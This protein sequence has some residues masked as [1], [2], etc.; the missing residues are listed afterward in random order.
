VGLGVPARE[1]LAAVVRAAPLEV[2]VASEALVEDGAE[3]VEVAGEPREPA[4]ELLH[5]GVAGA[6]VATDDGAAVPLR[7]PRPEAGQAE[8]EQ[9]RAPA[10]VE[11]DV[12]GVDVAVE[13]ALVVEVVQGASELEAELGDLLQAQPPLDGAEGVGEPLE[14]QVEQLVVEPPAVDGAHDVC[15]LEAPKGVGLALEGVARRV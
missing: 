14:S 5:G 4:H 13:D 8:V 1:G 15:V 10:G 3:G 7:P 9:L 6:T 2:A 12:A 11:G